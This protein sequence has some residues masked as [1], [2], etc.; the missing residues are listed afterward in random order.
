[1]DSPFY[2]LE[3]I[4]DLYIPVGISYEDGGTLV[5][6]YSFLLAGM[7]TVVLRFYIGSS[8]LVPIYPALSNSGKT[9]SSA[10]TLRTGLYVLLRLLLY[11]KR[12]Y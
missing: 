9:G 1:M 11:T 10:G 2:E 12:A 5:K 6:P 3:V 7:P 8:R 4:F